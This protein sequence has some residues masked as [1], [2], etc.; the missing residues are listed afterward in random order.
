VSRF[1]VQTVTANSRVADEIII[2]HSRKL[3]IRGRTKHGT[4]E[5]TGSITLMAED[6]YYSLEENLDQAKQLLSLFDLTRLYLIKDLD[7]QHKEN[8]GLAIFD[9]V[10]HIPTKFCCLSLMKGQRDLGDCNHGYGYFV[11]LLELSSFG[12]ETYQRIGIDIIT[13]DSLLD[14][15]VS[16][17]VSVI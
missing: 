5:V 16:G 1:R 6:S 11:L 3:R 12:E 13:S 8:V 17:Y 7:G 9:N 10:D 2:G 15:A 4:C 14:G